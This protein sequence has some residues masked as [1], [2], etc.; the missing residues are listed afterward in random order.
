MNRIAAALAV[1]GLMLLAV[2]WLSAQCEG[3][4]VL[5]LGPVRAIGC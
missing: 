5:W 1:L 4:P 2:L 3:Q